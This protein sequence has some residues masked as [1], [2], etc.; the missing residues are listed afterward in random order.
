VDTPYGIFKYDINNFCAYISYQTD[1]S[2][3]YIKQKKQITYLDNYLSKVSQHKKVFI[4]E[5][6]YIDKHYLEDYSSYYVKCFH[7]YKKTCSRIHFFELVDSDIDYKEEFRKAL[8]GEASIIN[9]QCYLGHIVIRPIPQTFLAK[10]CLR[11][12]YP[13]K[14]RL[15]NYL[16]SEEYL[17]SLFGINLSIDTIAFQEQDKILSAC[18]TTSLWS[19]FH[20]HPAMAT[21]YL[22]SSS[23]ITMSAYPEQNGF[24]REF[25][26]SGL[27]TDMI[28][29][30]LRA[31]DFVSEYFEFSDANDKKIALLKEYIFA[32]CSSGLPLILGVSVEDSDTHDTKGLHAITI[33]GYSL[34]TQVPNSQLIAHGLDKIYVH[35]D[36]YGPF[37][38]VKF[39]NNNLFI[40]L[41]E[42]HGV[43]NVITFPNEVYK[44]DTL[45]MGLYHKVRIP[46]SRIKT[47]CIDLLAYIS[48]YLIYYCD[49]KDAELIQALKWDIHLNKN[50]ELKADIL[51]REIDNKS[52]Y[53]TRFWPK[54][55]WDAVAYYGEVPIF[56]MIFDATDIDHG[57]V[58]LGIIPFNDKYASFIED[59]IKD[60][61]HDHFKN[62]IKQ[63]HMV[64]HNDSY[65]W[66]IIKYYREK[67]SYLNSLSDLFG[68]LKIP[69]TIKPLEIKDDTIV[70]RCDIKL[71]Q[72]NDDQKFQLKKELFQGQ[73][74]IWVIDKEGFLCIGIESELLRQGH[75]TL[76]DGMPAR[77]GGELVYS[78]TKEKWEVNP[79]SGRYSSDYSTEDR[80]RYVSNAIIYKFTVYFPEE[81]FCLLED[82]TL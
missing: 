82:K 27:S 58:F 52:K 22:P 71:N 32:Y 41:E 67:E 1:T 34:K 57:D 4:Y 23:Q 24:D 37:V 26:N 33:V 80:K 74:Y 19:F 10:V 21:L 51:K 65:V 69:I 45:I 43:S 39:D 7:S 75:P 68:Y 2:L 15:K 60:Y 13:E 48:E 61:S 73:K 17:I 36:R 44:P 62:K 46:Y 53:V 14:E 5:N 29:R 47:T 42:N 3:S 6:D 8:N 38:S 79:F 56:E 20:A 72:R 28:C 35:D 59:I 49:K 16:L 70:N 25:P 11:S 81:K 78:A 76:T 30:S 54:Y 12:Y 9:P 55:L 77:I 31:H 64:K 18:A 63:D 40:S 66:G 50:S